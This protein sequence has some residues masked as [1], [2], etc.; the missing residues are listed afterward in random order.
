MFSA[1]AFSNFPN[2]KQQPNKKK[3][4]GAR[5]REGDETK[6]QQTHV[7]SQK[8]QSNRMNKSTQILAHQ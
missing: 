3:N 6:T 1:I 2:V 8:M 7:S 5:E 4:K